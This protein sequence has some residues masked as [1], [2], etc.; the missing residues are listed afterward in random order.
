MRLSLTGVALAATLLALQ[1]A[2]RAQD[3]AQP[4]AAGPQMTASFVITPEGGEAADKITA[5]LRQVKGVTN[6]TGLSPE[7]KVATVSYVPSQVSVHQIAQA[8]ADLPAAAGRPYQ[9]SL[10]VRIVNLSEPATRDKAVTALRSVQGV[11]S[12]GPMDANAG[13]LAIQ[14]APL[15]PADRTGGPKGAT[16]EQIMKAL[17]TAGI[18]V[19]PEAAPAAAAQTR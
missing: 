6:V 16:Q 8:I 14:L 7:N 3:A 5:A 17:S 1:T 10:L 9:A 13:L 11:A 15:P 2:A 12:A 19:T 18:E 4:P